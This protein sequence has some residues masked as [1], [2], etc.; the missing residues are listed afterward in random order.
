MVKLNLKD[1]P[2]NG[3]DKEKRRITQERRETGRDAASNV[4]I[5]GIYNRLNVDMFLKMKFITTRN[6]KGGKKKTTTRGNDKYEDEEGASEDVQRNYCATK[7][8][9]YEREKKNKEQKQL[10]N[11]KKPLH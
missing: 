4:Y 5:Q 3:N 10:N 1:C 7:T 2:G 6:G 9:K 8:R 11:E